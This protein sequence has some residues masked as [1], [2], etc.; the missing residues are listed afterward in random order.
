[1]LQS[2]VYEA[3]RPTGVINYLLEG[4]L[5]DL[6]QATQG[7]LRTLAPSLEL[8][9]RPTRQTKSGEAVVEQ[10][11]KIVRVRV[12]G[13]NVLQDHAVKQLSG[14][15][16]RRLALA[17][18]LGFSSLAARRGLLRSNMLVLDEVTQHLDGEGSARLGGLLRTLPHSTILLI[19]QQGTPIAESART[20]DIVMKSNGESR[21]LMDVGAGRENS[22]ENVVAP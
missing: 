1:M 19:A 11:E 9:L 17:L 21:V 13:S 12:P 6:G 16:R 3:L 20:L 18:A 7:F 15:E 22:L 10:V 5:F 2:Q 4:V 8:Q 14:G